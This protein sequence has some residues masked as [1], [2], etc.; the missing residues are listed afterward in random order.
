LGY[1][2]KGKVY[3]F[4]KRGGTSGTGAETSSDLRNPG[5]ANIFT[6]LDEHGNSIDDGIFHLDPGQEPGNVYW[7]NMAANYHG[8]C[9]SISFADGHTEIV[10]MLE[11]GKL[12]RRSS[13]LPVVS[14]NSY[15]FSANYNSSPMFSGGHYQVM[16]SDDYQKL[17]SQM[18]RFR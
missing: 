11:R 4:T 2:P 8:G 15:A 3:H 14:N 10:K 5:P 17:S 16:D 12:G 13:M 1:D 6:F 18:P 9:Y 7:R